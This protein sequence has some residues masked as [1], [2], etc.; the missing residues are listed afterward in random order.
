MFY[1]RSSKVIS[2]IEFF[3]NIKFFFLS[4]MIGSRKANALYNKLIIHEPEMT[5]VFEAVVDDSVVID[6]GA[7][8]GYYTEIAARKA[9]LVV[10][11]EP[12]SQR[13]KELSR[14]CSSYDNV[15][16]VQKFIS[17]HEG[18]IKAF[19]EEYKRSWLPF[20]PARDYISHTYTSFRLH[21]KHAKEVKLP[22]ITLDKLVNSLNI[23][24]IDVV[25]MDI[26]GAELQAIRGANKILKNVKHLLIEFHYPR[27]DK[28]FLQCHH[29]LAELGFKKRKLSADGMYFYFYRNYEGFASTA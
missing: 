22:C 8:R 28:R 20:K 2:V 29:I 1:L 11:V 19:E 13:F 9:K 10:A 5:N 23:E 6:V 14:T 18:T 25:K 4:I 3:L 7:A 12:H 27:N 24:K 26:E 15:I 17:D 21:D 16:P